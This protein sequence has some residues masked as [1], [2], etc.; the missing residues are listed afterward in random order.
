MV[1]EP[2][3]AMVVL[4]GV[5][6]AGVTCVVWG[7][8]EWWKVRIQV[9]PTDAGNDPIFDGLVVDISLSQDHYT[10][11]EARAQAVVEVTNLLEHT[12][13]ILAP[14]REVLRCACA[15][16]LHMP[17]CADHPLRTKDS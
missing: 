13:G 12:V 14:I 4:R 7:W 5:I 3:S 6:A 8:E 1:T 11:H 9:H 15:D 2:T 17:W 16:Q 10:P